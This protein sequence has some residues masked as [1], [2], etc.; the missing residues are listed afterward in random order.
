MS[1]VPS[2][3]MPEPRPS[4]VSIWTTEGETSRGTRTNASWR[5]PAPAS[6]VV[7]GCASS[8]V[9]LPS[10]NAATA[11]AHAPPIPMNDLMAVMGTAT[12]AGA[13]LNVVS[14]APAG[15]THRTR[16]RGSVMAEKDER[17]DYQRTAPE[18]E[19]RERPQYHHDPR[20]GET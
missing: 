15:G 4:R 11:A 2:K 5:L 3:T 8:C 16:P 14:A 18:N 6:R 20:R 12:R 10:A 7:D 19:G 1:P 17:D 13:S 9:A